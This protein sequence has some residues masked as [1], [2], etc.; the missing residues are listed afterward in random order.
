MAHGVANWPGAVTLLPAMP[1][2]GIILIGFGG[3]WLCLWRR[4]W[5]LA[6][7]V[8]IA[9][10][11]M[12]IGVD[13]TPDVLVDGAAKLFAVRSADGRLMVSSTRVARFTSETWLRHA[14]Q[15]GSEPWPREGASRDGRLLCDALGCIYRAAGQVV[16]LVGDPRALAEDCHRA[17]VIVSLVPVRQACPPGRTVIDRFDLWRNG[18]YALW[19][20]GD[21]IAIQSVAQQSGRRLWSKAREK[22]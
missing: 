5:R 6:G 12:T 1:A 16:A 3:L 11:L 22:R 18:G 14:G 19:L 8:A 13:R 20:E 21:R 7:V 9:F 15:D 2:G 17:T 10:G 4:P